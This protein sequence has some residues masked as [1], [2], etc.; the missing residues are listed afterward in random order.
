MNYSTA[1]NASLNIADA[2]SLESLRAIEEELDR[3]HPK[4]DSIVFRFDGSL[5][6]LIVT[7]GKHGIIVKTDD[8]QGRHTTSKLWPPLSPGDQPVY[9]PGHLEVWRV[10]GSFWIGTRQD[11]ELMTKLTQRMPSNDR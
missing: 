7:M 1:S 8:N 5:S 4:R 11:L 6:E 2:S 3:E 10:A 9:T